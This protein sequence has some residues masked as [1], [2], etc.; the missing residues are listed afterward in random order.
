VIDGASA[1][2]SQG[3]GTTFSVKS[4]YLA[5]LGSIGT[6]RSKISKASA[7]SSLIKSNQ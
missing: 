1:I 3:G 7:V 2:L 6:P 5:S 4:G